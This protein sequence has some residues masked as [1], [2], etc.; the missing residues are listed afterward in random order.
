MAKKSNNTLLLVGAGLAAW[1]ILSR[2]NTASSLNFVPKGIAVVGGAVQ[3]VLGVQNPTSNGLNF[4]SLSGTV[5]VN[6]TALGNAASFTPAYIAPNAE[7]DIV[8]LV[9]PSFLGLANGILNTV[10]NGLTSGIQAVL[11]GTVNVNNTPF[12]INLNFSN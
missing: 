8:I 5:S 10:Q 6:G 11:T 7:S 12:P 2:Y 9:T 3:L 1:Y 4:D